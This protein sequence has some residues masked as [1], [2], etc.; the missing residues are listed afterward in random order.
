MKNNEN[1]N[2]ASL[3]LTI[4]SVE[5]G[6]SLQT[7]D[8]RWDVIVTSFYNHMYGITQSWGKKEGGF[9][10]RRSYTS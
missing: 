9:T 4:K 6:N 1:W 2:D 3:K 10:K 8:Q 5:I 7:I